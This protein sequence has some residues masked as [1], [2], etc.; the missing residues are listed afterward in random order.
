VALLVAEREPTARQRGALGFHLRDM[1]EGVVPAPFSF[2]RHQTVVR[3]DPIIWPSSPL[4]LVPRLLQGSFS[5]L[6]LHIMGRLDAVE[7][8][9]RRLDSRGLEG[10]QHGGRHGLIDSQAADRQA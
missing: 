6:P 8:R 5:G 2:S 9:E 4:D 3:I 10:L 1:G 7:R